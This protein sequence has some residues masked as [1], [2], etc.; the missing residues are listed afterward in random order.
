MTI[1]HQTTAPS[2][3]ILDRRFGIGS[4]NLELLLYGLLFVCSIGLHLWQLDHKAMHHDESIHA[5]MSYKF[6]SG[7]GSFDCADPDWTDQTPPPQSATY[8]YNPVYHGPTLYMLTLLAYLL[9]GAGDA[10]ARLPM[11]AA[12]IALVPMAWMLRQFIGRR[13]ALIAAA[14]LT[15]SPSI[16]YYTRFARHD[17][18]VL[19]WSLFVVVGLF[20]WLRE[21]GGFNL[22]L[23]AAGIALIW[24]THELVFILLFIFGSFLTLRLLWEWRPRLFFA[25]MG[26]ALVLSG[27]VILATALVGDESPTLYAWLHRLLGP[28]EMLAIGAVLLLPMA[29]SWDRTPVVRERLLGTWRDNRRE[30]WTAGATFL[31][32]FT[33]LFTV[34]FA[35]P[36]G[37]LDGWYQGLNYWLL[38]QHEAARGGQPWFYYL[39][40]LPIYELLALVFALT[41][42]GWLMW[43]GLRPL[44]VEGRRS[45]VEGELSNAQGRNKKTDAQMS[46]DDGQPVPNSL[47]A[48]F[49]LRPSTFDLRPSTFDPPLLVYFLG[50]W[51]ALALVG[52][53]WAGEKM[54]WL[55]THITLPAVLLAA[56]VLG[57]LLARVPWRE[58]RHDWGWAVAPLALLLVVSVGVAA[59]SFSGGDATVGGVQARLRGLVPLLA[60]GASL[61][62]LLTIAGLIGSRLVWRLSSLAVAGLL[63]LYTVRATTLVNFRHPDTPIEP[64]VYTQTAPDVPILVRQIE[65]I[66]RNETRDDRSAQDP[67][68]G[69]S[70]PIVLDSGSA[71]GG[72]EG[73]V[74]WPMQWYMREYQDLRWIDPTATPAVSPDAAVVVLSKQH[75][76]PEIEAQLETDWVRTS[77]GVFNWW[78][79]EFTAVDPERP[80]QPPAVGYKSL[81]EQGPL[82][83]LS[84]PLNPN[85]WGTLWNFLIYRKLPMELDGR[86]MVVYMRRDVVPGGGQIAAAVPPQTLA[87]TST[88]ARGELDNPRG[89]AVGADGNIYIADTNNH[90]I[91]VARPDGTVVRTFGTLGNGDGELN[92]P[93]GVSL[94]SDG[95]VYVADTWNARIAKFGP[96][97]SFLRHWGS[98]AV[99]YGDSFTDANG[100]QVQRFAFDTDGRLQ[101]GQANPLGF[102]GPRNVFVRGERVYIADTGNSRVVVTDLQGN[103]VQ[104][105]GS[106]GSAE[107]QLRE[108]IGLTADR[109]GRLYVGD[110]WNGRVQV[111]QLDEQGEADP[112]PVQ[113]FPIAGWAANTYNDPFIAAAPDGRLWA[114][115]GAR[116][117]LAE[118]DPAGTLLRTIRS[119][120]ALSG[121]KGVALSPDGTTL[122]VVNSGNGEVLE[123]EIETGRQGGGRGGEGER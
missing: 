36:R 99:P 33:L 42:V 84:W 52:F 49:D 40:L 80:E 61:F 58:L 89:M 97:G 46:S 19:L 76:T 26:G 107:G 114:A 92:E 34:F 69:H 67:T 102:F 12:G 111:F 82:A 50:Y 9:F 43:S 66:A 57:V 112:L 48:T 109:S 70:L 14:L 6:Y 81:A 32:V 59:F 1:Y 17:A 104:Q 122:Y 75:L 116:N 103:F 13:G 35:Y 41:G 45:K 123:F 74:A 20:K 115:Q 23:A 96:D 64:L 15:V 105:W 100:K 16:L 21:G 77:E 72:G 29:L 5:W 10:Q 38:S 94:D 108:P 44:L 54:P 24:A 63:L 91:V 117:T 90:R 39:M 78:F 106:A 86:E 62:G 83:V 113:S 30:Y 56:W 28:M 3:S 7:T 79:P 8:C 120:P 18:L 118:Y 4:L 119:E 55:L 101:T 73:S 98:G 85:N 121:P 31:V 93:S 51:F 47:P 53:S 27:L 71:A 2:R 60:A 22:S 88:L 95:N 87:A 68:G 65:Q 11:A 37:F 25:A 110:T